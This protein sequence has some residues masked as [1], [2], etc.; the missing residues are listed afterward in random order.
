M[1]NVV[2]NQ[3]SIDPVATS[4]II[5]LIV[6]TAF[7]LPEYRS[8]N[9]PSKLPVRCNDTTAVCDD[10]EQHGEKQLDGVTLANFSAP[11]EKLHCTAH[12]SNVTNYLRVEVPPQ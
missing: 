6:D 11:L 8:I 4:T 12:T 9:K 3:S 10:M 5:V 2:L 1:P 7:A